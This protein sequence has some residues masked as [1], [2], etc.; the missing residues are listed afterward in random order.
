[1]LKWKTGG[2]ESYIITSVKNNLDKI[3]LPNWWLNHQSNIVLIQKIPKFKGNNQFASLTFSDEM[4][5]GFGV[6]H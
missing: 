1:M 3:F 5:R 4:Q 2:V 6:G